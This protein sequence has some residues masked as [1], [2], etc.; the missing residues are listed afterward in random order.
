MENQS[1]KADFFL[2]TFLVFVYTTIVN[3][4]ERPE[5]IQIAGLFILTI[6]IASLVSRAMRATELRVQKVEMDPVA[7]R[8]LDEAIAGGTGDVRLLAHRPDGSDYA[9]KEAEAREIH[10]MLGP[11]RNFIF[12]EVERSDASEFVENCLEVS[13]HIVDGGFKVLRCD[14]PAVPNAIAAILLYI[15]DKTGQNPHAYFGWTE[16]NPVFY[17][18]KF[19]F[20]GEGET[21]P[22]TREI[23]R[24]LEHNPE[25]RPAIH[26]A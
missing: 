22:V 25:K 16:G 3:C 2:I 1:Q 5:G 24:E 21:A 9:I 13:G 14:S 26:V 17:I 23:L 18:F 7:K 20:F 6:F 4:V 10:S 8:F 15:R 11:D 12:L 19:L